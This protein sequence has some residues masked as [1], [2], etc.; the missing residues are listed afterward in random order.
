MKKIITVG[1][2]ILSKIT[3]AQ[4]IPLVLKSN[5]KLISIK[6]GKSYYK[7]AWETSP[8]LKL[9][10][11]N[12]NPFKDKEKIIFY[13]DIDTLEFEVKPNKKYDFVILLNGK[14]RALTQINTYKN[15][16]PNLEPKLFYSNINPKY[17]SETDTIP[18]R[19]GA[20]NRI[21][22]SGKVND[23]DTLDLIYDTGAG[24]SVI[25][26]SLIGNKVKIN[27]DGT[28]ENNGMDG[29]S[30]VNKSSK[31]TIKIG[32]YL[33]ENIPLLS[34]DYK[35]KTNFPFDVVLGW[36]VF[37]GKVVEIDYETQNI[38]LHN[39]VPKLSS[40]YSKLEFKLIEGIHYIK[41]K[42]VVNGIESE[43]WFDFDTG[44]NGNLFIGQKFAKE[45]NL[46]DAM[47]TIRKNTSKGSTGIEIE[48]KE[49]LLPKLIIGN[50]EMY[51]IPMAIQQ[52]EIENIEHNENIGNNILKR[53]NVFI[54]FNNETIYLKPNRLFY[55]K[56]WK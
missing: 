19:I 24:I 39:S 15:N 7:D 22:I 45:N 6:E 38:I 54:D 50:Y 30:T 52:K 36:L 55:S 40:E 35:S 32:N 41:S 49:A 26:S 18:F 53:F 2:I 43:T 48:N 44:S 8:E 11:F 3:F 5:T 21:H 29:I 12:A 25:T 17:K 20:D 34:I 46:N 9:D 51:Q 27:L 37:E 31:N 33:W 10:V 14:E 1:L 28:T 23:S 4:K 13:S 42:L 47:K 56:M 16:K